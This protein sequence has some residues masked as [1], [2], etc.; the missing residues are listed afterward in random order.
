[1][2]TVRRRLDTVEVV[3]VQPFPR[4]VVVLM[5]T[6]YWGRNCG[7]MLFKDALTG[8]NLL[9]YHVRHETNALYVRGVEC[10]RARGFSVVGIVC[11]GRKGLVQSFPDTP[12][13]MC[14]SHQT[15]ILRRHLTKDPKTPAAVGL[16]EIGALM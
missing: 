13:Q 8:D 2:R 4:A 9:W 6:T 16:K 10:L 12:V 7:V 14:Q 5:D 1:M 11:D 3:T 15:A